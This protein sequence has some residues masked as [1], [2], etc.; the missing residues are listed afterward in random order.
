MKLSEI[1]RIIDLSE[2]EFS[3][4]LRKDLARYCESRKID[5][6]E[7]GNI[8]A[9]R[10][11]FGAT[12]TTH[13]LTGAVSK[14]I[15]STKIETMPTELPAALKKSFLFEAKDDE[16]LFDD[17]I[18]I[19]G[20]LLDGD[21]VLI[22]A[23]QDEN[24]FWQHEK[25]AYDGRNLSNIQ[26]DREITSEKFGDLWEKRAN[27]KDTFAF[28]TVLALMMEAERTPIVVDEGTK[29]AKKRNNKA[30][31]WNSGP[32]WIERR[33]YINAKYQS[34]NKDDHISLNKDGKELKS[35]HVQGFL[36][37]QPYGP[38]HKL[39]KWV[40]IEGFDSTRWAKHG[41]TKIIVGIHDK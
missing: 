2:F 20:F 8:I 31:N 10:L 13:V 38:R 6:R 1:L 23:Y 32:P 3:G 18:A 36:R 15:V 11:S 28:I 22:S 24:T 25:G 37:N 39:R 14:K 29:K 30:D 27:R 4:D 40:Y 26:F 17:V 19:G 16:T 7:Y 21:L 9:Y 5:I 34:D 35:V 12:L 33:V 41:H